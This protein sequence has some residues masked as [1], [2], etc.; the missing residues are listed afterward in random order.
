MLA[1][2]SAATR[3]G[4]WAPFSK[5]QS[6]C[7]TSRVGGRPKDVGHHWA[8]DVVAEPSRPVSRRN[9]T[10]H[11]TH[12]CC[13]SNPNIP[14]RKPRARITTAPYLQSERARRSAHGECMPR[15]PARPQSCGVTNRA[16]S[17]DAA[18]TVALSAIVSL[19]SSSMASCVPEQWW[20]FDTLRMSAFHPFCLP[21]ARVAVWFITLPK[22]WSLIPCT[23]RTGH[24]YGTS[25][26]CDACTHVHTMVRTYTYSQTFVVAI[27]PAVDLAVETVVWVVAR[28]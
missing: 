6:C 24:V 5:R 25:E 8:S 19:Q 3:R 20:Q 11:A 14:R 2:A 21:T 28:V 27:P 26:R 17:R 18:P 1:V 22:E 10:Q 4:M 13:C 15:P 23:T 16:T 12:N 7:R 9:D